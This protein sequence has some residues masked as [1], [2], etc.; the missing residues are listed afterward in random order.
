[1]AHSRLETKGAIADVDENVVQELISQVYMNPTDRPH[2]NVPIQNVPY[3]SVKGLRWHIKFEH[4]LQVVSQNKLNRS[5][6][7]QPRAMCTARVTPQGHGGGD[8]LHFDPAKEQSN[9]KRNDAR[10][11]NEEFT[12]PKRAID[13]DAG[14]VRTS[15]S[16][17]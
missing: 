14:R 3:L 15:G 11:D 5:R 7:A 16:S 9:H 4:F 12:D 8:V 1:M 10:S 13:K 17:L 2:L 6:G